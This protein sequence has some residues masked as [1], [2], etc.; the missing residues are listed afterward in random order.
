V[1]IVLFY[2]DGLSIRDI[3]EVTGRTATDI[4]VSLHRARKI[5]KKKWEAFE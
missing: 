5:L 1:P 2:I 3:V 4:R